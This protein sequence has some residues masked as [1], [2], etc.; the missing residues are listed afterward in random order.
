VDL[1]QWNIEWVKAPAVWNTTG[2]GEGL[3]YANADTGVLWQHETLRDN[4]YGVKSVNGRG[5][6]SVNHNY[7]WFDGVKRAL[8]P[9][10]GPCGI[11][12]PEPCDD[13]GHGTHTTRFVYEYGNFEY[14]KDSLLYEYKEINCCMNTKRIHCFINTKING[15]TNTK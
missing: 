6:V 13:N 2:R 9:G 7:A 11:N 8:T 4:Y 15:L 1:I 3:I 10:Q 5:K 14:E 12:S